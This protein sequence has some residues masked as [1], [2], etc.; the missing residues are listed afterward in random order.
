MKSVTTQEKNRLNN[1]KINE[2]ICNRTKIPLTEWTEFLLTFQ[3]RIDSTKM[4]KLLTGIFVF[5][6]SAIKAAYDDYVLDYGMKPHMRDCGV[7]E[8]SR[9]F[10]H[11]LTNAEVNVQ[12]LDADLGDEVT[13]MTS[14][15]NVNVKEVSETELDHEIKRLENEID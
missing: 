14:A 1:E 11:Y 9:R 8:K 13:G 7:P 3:M 6:P 4:K 10:I 15:Y 12:D 2:E 5:T